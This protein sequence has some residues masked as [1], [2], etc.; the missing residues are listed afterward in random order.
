[1]TFYEKTIP[2]ALLIGLFFFLFVSVTFLDK[3]WAPPL[4]PSANAYTTS[5]HG[6]I[7]I[8]VKRTATELTSYSRGN[9][10][11]CHE[12]HA[13]IAGVEPDPVG[14]APSP[15]ALFA[16]PNPT[17]QTTNF[18]FNCHVTVGAVQSGGSITNYNYNVNFGGGPVAA[19]SIYDAFNPA[20]GSAHNLNQIST[21]IQ[22]QWPATFGTQSNP[23]GGC[24]NPH[25]AKKNNRTGVAYDATQAAISRPTDHEDL[26]GNDASE[27]MNISAGVN[28]YRAPFFVGANPA[29]DPTLHEPDGMTRSILSV[30]VQGSTT[31][32]YNTFCLDCH[33]NAIPPYNAINWSITG[34]QHGHRS[35]NTVNAPQVLRPPYT[36]DGTNGTGEDLPTNFVLSCLDCHEPHGTQGANNIYL[37]RTTV[38]G[39]VGAAFSSPTAF[40]NFCQGCHVTNGHGF[41]PTAGCGGLGCHIHGQIF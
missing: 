36:L 37:L 39:M 12:Q 13:S 41:P 30:Q 26:W 32:D 17:S 38:N 18:C 8:G 1:M 29:V 5:A 7:T 6:D 9:C 25:I 33:V 16:D 10:A 35:G 28:T 22:T 34:D 3:A 27:R 23:C 15:Y 14:G 4:P 31:P 2:S 24:H 40:Y 20:T 21:F 11:H 19:Q